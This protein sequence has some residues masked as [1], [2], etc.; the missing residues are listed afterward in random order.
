MNGRDENVA[1]EALVAKLKECVAL[2]EVP[3]LDESVSEEEAVAAGE[4]KLRTLHFRNINF[5]VEALD[6]GWG[7]LIDRQRYKK[8][9]QVVVYH[10]PG[11]PGTVVVYDVT[12]RAYSGVDLYKSREHRYA[13]NQLFCRLL[14]YATAQLR[15]KQELA[16]KRKPK[17]KPAD[18]AQC[19]AK[20]EKVAKRENIY[21]KTAALRSFPTYG[22]HENK[23]E[24]VRKAAIRAKKS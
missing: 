18:A 9:P 21:V 11:N 19:I 3:A 8:A 1:T 23:Y 15:A 24:A 12:E 6:A 17:I 4:W 7:K 2:T 14:G 5:N 13:I 22:W 20:A 16:E 10:V